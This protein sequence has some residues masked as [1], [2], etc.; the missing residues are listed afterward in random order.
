MRMSYIF[1]VKKFVM[2]LA[3]GGGILLF[4]SRSS[5]PEVQV[6]AFD[7]VKRLAE[8]GDA[9]E[10]AKLGWMYRNGQGVKQDS[11]EA[12]KWLLK[13]AEQGEAEGQCHLGLMYYVGEGVEL[14]FEEAVKWSRKAADQNHAAAQ[15]SLGVM[16]ANGQGV[17]L[18]FEE[19]M[20]WIRKAAQ[21][22]FADALGR[23][24]ANVSRWARD[25]SGS[26]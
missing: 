25:R 26:K 14:N 10:Q 1:S 18:D 16:Y 22:G 9:H 24:R 8:S 5:A 19:G 6:N 13:A 15:F 7:S 11:M 20:K 4:L 23:S 2:T 3:I 17:E 12:V 21:Q